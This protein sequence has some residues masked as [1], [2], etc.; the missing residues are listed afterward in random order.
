MPIT[1]PDICTELTDDAYVFH[2]SQIDAGEMLS[3]DDIEKS[4]QLKE[5]YDNLLTLLQ[6]LR[7]GLRAE[8][9]SQSDA[10]ETIIV[11]NTPSQV[12]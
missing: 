8:C 2:A 4:Q 12:K 5:K 6:W 3:F 10:V 11:S 1:I 9:K 7:E